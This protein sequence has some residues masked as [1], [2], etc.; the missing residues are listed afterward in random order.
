MTQ[1]GAEFKPDLCEKVLQPHEYIKAYREWRDSATAAA[2]AASAASSAA[3]PAASAPQ[4]GRPVPSQGL[5]QEAIEAARQG[6]QT[7]GTHGYPSVRREPQSFYMAVDDT[8]KS[9]VS[10]MDIDLEI[11]AKK[12]AEDLYRRIIINFSRLPLDELK[13][14]QQYFETNTDRTLIDEVKSYMDE[15]DVYGNYTGT[16]LMT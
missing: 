15:P 3:A 13:I 10:D 5:S 14:R 7:C 4:G 2:A 11:E 12:M 9:T 16:L 8:P 1:L 6:R